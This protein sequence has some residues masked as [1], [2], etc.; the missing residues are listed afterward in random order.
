MIPKMIAVQTFNSPLLQRPPIPVGAGQE[1]IRH[2]F[3]LNNRRGLHSRPA[4][5]LIKTLQKFR[6]QATVECN[7]SVANGR[8]VFEL[9]C[10]AA[11]FGSKLTFAMSGSDAKAAM[12]AV[13]G[14]F[15]TNFAQAYAQHDTA[16]DSPTP[17]CHTGP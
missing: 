17:N 11:C 13:Q 5:L 2:T 14:L 6:C 10:L 15:D 9:M 12:A 4:I 7:G 3:V 8:S 1:A 16:V